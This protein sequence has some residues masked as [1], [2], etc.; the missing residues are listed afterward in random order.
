M[1]LLRSEPFTRASLIRNV[2]TGTI[3]ETRED[4]TSGHIPTILRNSTA[5]NPAVEV[6]KSTVDLISDSGEE[7]IGGWSSIRERK[8]MPMESRYSIF[9][10]KSEDEDAGLG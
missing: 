9:S 5:V 4:R 2:N 7:R 3:S 10:S 1:T 6:T 8:S